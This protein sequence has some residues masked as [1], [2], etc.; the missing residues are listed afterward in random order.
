MGSL[1]GSITANAY[2]VVGELPSD[3]RTKAI[4]GLAAHKFLDINLDLDR[5]ESWG[6]VNTEDV[7]DTNFD[8]AKVFWG[9]YVMVTLRHDAI[10][11]PAATFKVKLKKACE[12]ACRA[13]GVN[14]LSKSDK[15]D[16]KERLTS[17]LKKTAIPNI[18]TFDMV[19]NLDRGVVWFFA[20]NKKLNESFVDLFAE[21]FGLKLYERCPYSVMESL[22]LNDK[23]LALACAAEGAAMS[24]PPASASKKIRA[25]G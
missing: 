1:S 25:V 13:R 4:E 18:K 8:T 12:D 9:S 11:I 2:Y 10:K 20:T 14:K 23:Q 6:W 7:T 24:A 15:N 17:Q 3:I 16:I 5:E 22:N 21:T 19:W